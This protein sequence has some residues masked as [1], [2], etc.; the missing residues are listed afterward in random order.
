MSKRGTSKPI[1]ARKARKAK[2][3]IRMVTKW[4]AIFTAQMLNNCVRK[5][6]LF[7]A[8]QTP[9]KRSSKDMLSQ[10][11]KIAAVQLRSKQPV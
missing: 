4:V 3:T 1:G 10:I 8:S 9:T 6:R 7:T 5:R 11:A 2:P